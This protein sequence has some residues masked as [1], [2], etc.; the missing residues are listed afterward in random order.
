MLPSVTLNYAKISPL[1]FRQQTVLSIWDIFGKSAR[2]CDIAILIVSI[3]EFLTVIDLCLY[4]ERK[5]EHGTH[6]FVGF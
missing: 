6:F 4:L 2:Q 5:A 1:F 3:F